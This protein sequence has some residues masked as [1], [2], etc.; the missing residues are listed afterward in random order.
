MNYFNNNADYMELDNNFNSCLMYGMIPATVTTLKFGKKY[1]KPLR[2]GVIPLSVKVLIF[3]KKFNQHLYPGDIPP[4]VTEL[5]FGKNFN[6]P[7]YKG[8]IPSSVINL[9][10]GKKFNQRIYRDD[11]PPSVVSLK[12]GKNFNRMLLPNTIPNSVVHLEFGKKFRQPYL[13]RKLPNYITIPLSMIIF[14][15]IYFT[16][17]PRFK[18]VS[19]TI[20][21]DST[22]FFSTKITLLGL[23]A[24]WIL[25]KLYSYDY[26]QRIIG[27]IIADL[28]PFITYYQYPLRNALPNSIMN[29]YFH[30]SYPFTKQISDR[31]YEI[32]NLI[33]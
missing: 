7:L 3:G 14:N 32:K 2:P 11:I 23:C 27:V 10:L 21:S 5:V 4:S 8:V 19:N 31:P 1:N 16:Y 15:N 25:N 33:K 20:I 22:T 17:I 30:H 13:T 26:V 29:L 24:P 6:K 28:M 9:T 18:L 12:F